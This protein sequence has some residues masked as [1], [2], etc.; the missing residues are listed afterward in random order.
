MDPEK[1]DTYFNQEQVEKNLEIIKLIQIR[2]DQNLEKQINES[3]GFI[4]EKL[5]DRYKTLNLIISITGGANN[6]EF[7]FNFITS[8]KDGLE[9]LANSTNALFITGKNDVFLLK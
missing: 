1:A 4:K 3:I 2:N 5:G 9:K 8:Y 6:F 7:P